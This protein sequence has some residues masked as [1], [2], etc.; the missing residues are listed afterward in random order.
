[1]LERLTYIPKRVPDHA[2]QQR[3]LGSLCP[4]TLTERFLA[5]YP[6]EQYLTIITGSAEGLRSSLVGF[7]EGAMREQYN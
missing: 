2:Y 5:D 3:R 6:I 7:E 1:M 4:F